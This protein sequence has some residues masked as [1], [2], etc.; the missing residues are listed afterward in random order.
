MIPGLGR[1]HGE[2]H[3]N[4]LQY[5]C[6]EN[7]HGQRSLVCYSSWGH[8]ESDTT[9][10]L[11]TCSKH[12]MKV[13]VTQSFSTLCDPHGLYSPWNSPGKNTGVGSRSLLQD[14]FLTQGSNPGLP[15]CRRILYQLSHKG[16]PTVLRWVACPFSGNLPNQGI[17]LGSPILQADFLPAELPGKP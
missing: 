17:E 1:S 2:G 7:P 11:S 14:I 15:H 8:K 4:P 6:L 10:Q 9:E 12:L 3:G 13:K 5:S 16:S